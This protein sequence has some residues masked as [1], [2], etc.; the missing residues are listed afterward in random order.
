[1]PQ[2]CGPVVLLKGNLHRTRYQPGEQLKCTVVVSCVDNNS[3]LLGK[4]SNPKRRE[5]DLHP[6]N[7]SIVDATASPPADPGSPSV[8]SAKI[9]V[10]SCTAQFVGVCVL[11][12][13]RMVLPKEDGLKEH[14]ADTP[15][16]SSWWGSLFGHSGAQDQ[17]GDIN[18][19]QRKDID[20][21]LEVVSPSSVCQT[22]ATTSLT[23]SPPISLMPTSA[24]NS[25]AG[26]GDL[27]GCLQLRVGEAH[28]GMFTLTIPTHLPPSLRTSLVRYLYGVHVSCSYRH[29]GS[30]VTQIV[31]LRLPLRMYTPAAVLYVLRPPFESHSTGFDFDIKTYVTRGDI[32]AGILQLPLVEAPFAPHL[33]VGRAPREAPPP[34][35][36]LETIADGTFTVEIGFR[37]RCAAV[38]L[39]QPTQSTHLVEIARVPSSSFRG[40]TLLEGGP[41]D[42]ILRCILFQDTMAVGGILRGILICPTLGNILPPYNKADIAAHVLIEL[43]MLELAPKSHFKPGTSMVPQMTDTSTGYLVV[44]CTTVEEMDFYISHCTESVPFEVPLTHAKVQQSTQTSHISLEWRLR[45]SVESVNLG[46]VLEVT[47]CAAGHSQPLKDSSAKISIPLTSPAC[48]VAVGCQE[49]PTT[50]RR[51]GQTAVVGLRVVAPPSVQST[52]PIGPYIYNLS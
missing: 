11:D 25:G 33:I 32:T 1:M 14:I 22:D 4:V 47:N 39:A 43:E 46:R 50:N 27:W 48:E 30:K 17:I 52:G 44:S 18:P 37:T 19:S 21:Q 38:A 49:F 51:V 35:G 16:T 45:I 31:N 3:L 26:D 5:Q 13:S 15:S 28:S 7:P 24:N 36:L 34:L 9:N 42:Y 8:D 20:L 10:L 40:D 6:Y 41:S 23:N 2:G 29:P 12:S